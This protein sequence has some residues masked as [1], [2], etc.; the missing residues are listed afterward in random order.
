[1][2]PEEIISAAMHG[3]S[4]AIAYTYSEPLVHAEY[5]LDCMA[6]AR[7]HG[8]ANVLVTNGCVNAAPAG[9]IL[10]L[11][12][13]ANIDLKCFSGETY[14]KT[15]GGDLDTVLA[16]IR[17][18][19]Q[20]NVHVEITTLIVPG[21]NDN[22]DELENCINFIDKNIPWHLSAYH[23]EYRWNAPPTDPR[24]LVHI[25]EIAAKKIDNV[26]TGNVRGEENDTFC[27]NCKSLL[28]RRRG[29]QVTLPGL[30]EP[31]CGEKHYRCKQCRK[32]TS[33]VF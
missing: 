1:M 31:A 7:R 32:E 24:F 14:R 27:G 3:N 15:L 26:Y 33:I 12:D 4:Q 22:E 5:L 21:L 19:M 23:P 29:Y 20:K 17:L 28:V 10:S 18:A 2:P 25:R 30:A 6:L 16:F 8:I 9:E 11:A 13:A